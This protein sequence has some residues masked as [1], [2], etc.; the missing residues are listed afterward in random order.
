[1]SDSIGNEIKEV[2][3]IIMKYGDNPKG[4]IDLIFGL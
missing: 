3:V 4:Q 2:I 1:M